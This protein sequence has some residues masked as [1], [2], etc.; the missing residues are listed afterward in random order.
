MELCWVL[1]R[2][3]GA[4]PIEIGQTVGDLLDTPRF[5]LQHRD[6]VREALQRF[7]GKVA[8]TAGFADILIARIAINE[9]CSAIVSFDRAAVRSAG[10]T[11]LD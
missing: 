1:E 7:Q 8:D 4:T 11:L 6:V 10:M 3:Y 9:G 5:H 2:L